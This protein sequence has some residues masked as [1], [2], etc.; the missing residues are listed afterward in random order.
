MLLLQL[1]TYPYLIRVLGK[2][3]YGII[4]YSQAI[5]SYF[6]IFIN[7][8][9]D[10]SATLQI[11][12]NRDQKDKLTEIIS[13]TFI[14]K[15][16]IFLCSLMIL[17]FI[18][19]YIP[20]SKDYATLI[21]ITFFLSLYNVFFP[22]WYFQGIEKMGYITIFSLSS[23]IFFLIMIFVFVKS[24][25]D[26][27]LVP[28][29]N[30]LGSIPICI[31]S[32]Y[33]IVIKH[34]IPLKLQSLN[35]LIYYIRDSY[36]IFISNLSSTIYLASN[37]VIVG[38]FLGLTEVAYYDL[39]EK[40]INIAKLPQVILTS[41][42]FPKIGK[43]KNSAFVLKMFVFSL[44]VNILIMILIIISSDWLVLIL[45]GNDMY[46][47]GTIIRILSITIPIIAISSI[48]GTQY[49]LPFNHKIQFTRTYILC[50]FLY[51][52]C[53]IGIYFYVG[54]TIYN[55]LALIILVELFVTIIMYV[56]VKRL[57][58]FL[59]I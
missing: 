55:L 59:K 39:A 21:Y 51:F 6:I 11:S 1:V 57:G 3:T 15:L 48:F 28:I 7:F 33:L 29:I 46:S 40:I 56:Y 41:A 5:I 9:F 50:G 14:I 20:Y 31:S 34:K 2:D 30:G 27:L 49:L 36:L 24:P 54:F 47:A 23:R 45:G 18:F 19:K 53:C 38:S 8:G 52:F 43:E 12:V 10:F 32:L 4:V 35:N 16:F 22:V 37:K 44:F 26:Y 13:S 42:L 25:E 58:L 17:L